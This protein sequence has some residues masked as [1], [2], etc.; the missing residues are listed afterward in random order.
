MVLDAE[1]LLGLCAEEL[2]RRRVLALGQLLVAL[3]VR[4]ALGVEL[5]ESEDKVVGGD[6]AVRGD[7]ALAAG[8]GDGEGADV[9]VGDC[10]Q[11]GYIGSSLGVSARRTIAHIDPVERR[12]R[13]ELA[14]LVVVR[15]P[16][17]DVSCKC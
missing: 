12:S 14:R 9:G 5:G 8:L 17:E 13:R 16:V 11:R 15:Q 4:L 7:E 1:H 3:G 6:G 10:G 2:V